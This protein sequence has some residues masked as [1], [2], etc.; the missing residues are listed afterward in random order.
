MSTV[1]RTVYP[2][3]LNAPAREIVSIL[4]SMPLAAQW[5]AVECLKLFREL[6][7]DPWD[8]PGVKRFASRQSGPPFQL[9]LAAPPDP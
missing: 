9:R 3:H 5:H 4:E 2:P 1:S 8:L 7:P 6:C